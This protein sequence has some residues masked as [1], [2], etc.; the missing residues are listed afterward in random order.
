VTVTKINRVADSQVTKG[1]ITEETVAHTTAFD[2]NGFFASLAVTASPSEKVEISILIPLLNEVENIGLLYE[3]LSETLED[4]GKP[5]EIIFVD[6]GSTDGSYELLRELYAQDDQVR[7]ICFRRNFGQT[8]AFAAGFELASGDVVI[9]MDADLQNDPRDIP[10][11][12]A[13]LDEG[14][15]IVSGWR[16]DRK[17][18]YLTRRIPSQ[19]ANS[20]ISKFTG[21]QL[22]DYGCSLKAYRIDVVKNIKLYGEM[23]RFIPAVAS[24]MGVRVAEIP[25]NHRPRQFGQSKYGLQRTVKVFLDLLTVKFLLS[26]GT[27]PI[28]VFGLLGMLCFAGG[29]LTGAYLSVLKLFYGEPLADRPLLLLAVLLTV[30]GVQF[31]TMGLLGELVVRT[32]HESQK[33][34]TYMVRDLLHN[35]FTPPGEQA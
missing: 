9:T 22:H 5:Y 2:A 34:S 25:V 35:T 21:V 14:Y 7:V 31:I 24:W 16:I 19:V 29:T 11:L 20:L 32:Y 8:A 1:Q 10:K 23:H 13:K 33:K 17:D 4:L 28:H 6:D 30:L 18:K 12:L 26:F 15:D 27:R 3:Q